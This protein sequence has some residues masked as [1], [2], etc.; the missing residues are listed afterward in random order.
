MSDKHTFI[1]SNIILYLFT[2][3]EGKKDIVTSLL[4][5][6]YTISTQV[7]NENV[8]VCLRKLKLNKEEAFNHGRDLLNSMKIV[9]IHSSTISSAFDLSERYGFGYWDSL[10]VAAA[11]ENGAA[12]EST[13]AK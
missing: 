1:D 7:V 9:N 2:D 4:N 6:D 11:I 13:S 3:N 10:I 12:A 8:N 5:L